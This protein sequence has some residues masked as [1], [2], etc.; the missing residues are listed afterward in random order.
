MPHNPD[1]PSRWPPTQPNV[2]QLYSMATPNGQKIGICLEEL[3]LSY[4]P[5]LI[6]ITRNDQAD[7]EF[8]RM[9][10]NGK[11]PVL[12][13]PNGPE[14]EPLLLAESIVILQYLADK[15]GQL[16]PQTYRARM[17]ALQWLTL[18]A[19]H[20]GP[21]FGQFGHF[22]LFARDK[23]S[24]NYAVTRY[25]NEA[26]RLLGVL[27]RRLADREY[28]IGEYSI[29]DIAHAPWVEGLEHTYKGAEVLE[30]DSFEHL[31]RWRTRVTSR[32]AYQRGKVVCQRP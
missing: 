16:F 24:D 19:A 8:L 5:H 11:I 30:L 2:I 28:L 29:V 20:T 18:Q 7:P 14:G 23:T 17:D 9:N 31:Q 10:P 32:P 12:L 26:K 6:D 27:D 25:T 3:G 4:E 1:F 22:F 15:T 21:M 13:D